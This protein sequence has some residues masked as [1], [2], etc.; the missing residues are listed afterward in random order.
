MKLRGR[1]CWN[2]MA[3]IPVMF[4]LP[5]IIRVTEAWKIRAGNSSGRYRNSTNGAGAKAFILMY[6][7]G[8]F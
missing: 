6:P 3:L 5:L 1:I 7:T 2:M 4:V 8:I